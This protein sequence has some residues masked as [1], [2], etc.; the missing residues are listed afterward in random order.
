MFVMMND[1]GTLDSMDSTYTFQRALIQ[2]S[3][4]FD[5]L[6]E[7]IS[8]TLLQST[9]FRESKVSITGRVSSHTH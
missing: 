1:G 2:R 3:F 9:E 4:M 6:N 8:L 5:L 7:G